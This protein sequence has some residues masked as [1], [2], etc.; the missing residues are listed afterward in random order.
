MR[1]GTQVTEGAAMW[2]RVIAA[3]EKLGPS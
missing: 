3:I 1:I 2:R